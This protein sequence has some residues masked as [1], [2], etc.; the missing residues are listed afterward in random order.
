[1]AVQ[2]HVCLAKVNSDHQCDPIEIVRKLKKSVIGKKTAN[3]FEAHA[4][5]IFMLQY[6]KQTSYITI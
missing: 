3:L 6:Y 1:M 2:F 5:I 4:S